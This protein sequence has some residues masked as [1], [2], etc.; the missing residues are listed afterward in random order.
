[1]VNSL[2]GL[3]VPIPTKPAAEMRSA[4]LPV[5]SNEMVSLAGNLIAVFVSPS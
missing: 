3:S 5:V 2:V 4:S 1:M